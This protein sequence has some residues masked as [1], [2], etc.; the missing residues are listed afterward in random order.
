[1]NPSRTL[2]RRTFVVDLGRGSL[3]LAVLG[4]AG[5]APTAIGS[6]APSRSLAAS[7]SASPGAST[8]ASPGATASGAPSTS[9]G[10][11]TP[12]W[13]RVNL[14][15]VS[16]YILVHGG[17]AAI[18]DTGVEGSGDAIAAALTGIGLDWPAVVHVILTH[19]HGDHA[20]SAADVL[21]RAADAT[22][23][24][25]AED[26][27]GITVPRPLTPVQDGDRVFDLQV[28]AAPGH[29]AGSI[30]VL[31]PAAGGILV[32]GD[33][34]GTSGGAPSLPGSQFTADME[35]AKASI[36]KLGNLSFETLLVGHG[37]PIESGAAALVAELGAGG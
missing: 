31:D 18:V 6:A 17:E 16:A 5:C 9:A 2:D 29:T 25:G 28:V 23:Y 24:A 32:A 13:S 33:A 7:G 15:F 14:G 1:V 37:E 36:V 34:L 30:A 22:G 3:A 20:G 27:A 12:A 4:I 10:P 35:Q 8:S 26:I 19:N 11:G 21:D